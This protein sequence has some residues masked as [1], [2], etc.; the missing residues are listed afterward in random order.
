MANLRDI[1]TKTEPDTITI[2][3]VHYALTDPGSLSTLEASRLRRQARVLSEHATRDDLSEEEAMACDAALA[4]VFAQVAPSVPPEVAAKL[5]PG[6]MA[7]VIEVFTVRPSS[8]QAS[9]TPSGTAS[10]STAGA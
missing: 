10:D 3:G 6:Q 7:A 1:S 2:D 9:T 8:A 4:S 5:A